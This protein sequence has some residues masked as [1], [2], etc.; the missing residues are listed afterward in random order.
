MEPGRPK[1]EPELTKNGAKIEK[2]ALNRPKWLPDGSQ[3]Y[4]LQKLPPTFTNF[5]VPSGTQKSTQNACFLENWG[6]EATLS[7]IF[8]RFLRLHT[9]LV[10]FWSFF[11]KKINVF[12]MLF[13]I[14]S[15]FFCN[16]AT[17][18]KHC[19]LQCF[20]RFSDFPFFVFLQKK[21]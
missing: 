19:V 17:L 9:F 13:P 4:F 18:T 1:M 5:W 3:D 21:W 11:M 16:L 7:S 14:A 15:C 2:N 6:T 12:S 8:P 20:V 10:D